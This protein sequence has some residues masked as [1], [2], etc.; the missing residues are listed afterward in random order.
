[1]TWARRSR[2]ALWHWL[3]KWRLTWWGRPRIEPLW[4]PIWLALRTKRMRKILRL[5]LALGL[6]WSLWVPWG[7][8]IAVWRGSIVLVLGIHGPLL[9]KGRALVGTGA[10]I[11]L[12]RRTPIIAINRLAHGGRT[13]H[14]VC[15]LR[16]HGGCT[17]GD[18]HLRLR[19]HCLGAAGHGRTGA[20]DVCECCVPCSSGLAILRARELPPL[21]IAVVGHGASS[22]AGACRPTCAS[23][24]V[25]QAWAMWEKRTRATHYAA[26]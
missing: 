26:R 4:L 21:L 22:V 6:L 12:C 24:A 10:R 2:K 17:V 7:S 23:A 16:R 19:S 8:G 3:R 9:C 20:E 11:V 18:A 14:H 25:G 5:G 13:L 15:C 1:M